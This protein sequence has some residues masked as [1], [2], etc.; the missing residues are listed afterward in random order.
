MKEKGTRKVIFHT[1]ERR[2]K[3]TLLPLIKSSVQEECKIHSDCWRAYHSLQ[4]EGYEH[5]TVNHSEHFKAEDGTCTNEIKGVWSLVKLKI[6]SMK[7]ILHD[8]IESVL[9]EFT[10]RHRYG[11]PSGDVYYQLVSD[12]AKH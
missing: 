12:I 7:G 2:N 11:L 5:S 9:D 3:D 1:V 6:K 10:H 8:K 4:A